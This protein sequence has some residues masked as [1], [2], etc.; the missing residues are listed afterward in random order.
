MEADIETLPEWYIHCSVEHRGTWD[1][2]CC[3]VLKDSD[4]FLHKASCFLQWNI[5]LH[6]LKT[7]RN[8]MLNYK[9]FQWEYNHLDTCTVL[10]HSAVRIFL[11]SQLSKMDCSTFLGTEFVGL[12]SFRR[13]SRYQRL[14]LRLNNF[15]SSP[16]TC[17]KR[18]AH[19]KVWFYFDIGCHKVDF[20]PHS[21]LYHNYH[22][23][24]KDLLHLEKNFELKSESELKSYKNKKGLTSTG[25]QSSTNLIEI[26][27]NYFK[28]RTGPT[29]RVLLVLEVCYYNQG[30]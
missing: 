27:G 11:H 15:R 26:E 3:M 13:T 5:F 8:H 28:N 18:I 9:V 19:D 10:S 25:G 23:N 22:C 16:G 29:G 30:Y 4:I 17:G 6:N 2:C 21:K 1:T 7:S 14:P 20:H 12:G 24:P